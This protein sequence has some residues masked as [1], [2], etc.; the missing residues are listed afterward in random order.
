MVQ[1][2][3]FVW[4]VL[5]L[6]IK[7]ENPCFL[8]KTL[9]KLLYSWTRFFSKNRKIILSQLNYQGDGV[10][11]LIVIFSIFLLREQSPVVPSHPPSVAG[12]WIN[13]TSTEGS[14]SSVGRK[15][16]EHELI[17]YL[18][19]VGFGPSLKTWPKCDPQFLQLTSVRINSGLLMISSKFPP[20]PDASCLYTTLS[21]PMTS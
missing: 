9:S 7:V 20:I 13:S 17:Q 14:E 19:P 1:K 2:H 6:K 18:C 10:S 12:W 4:C 5:Q 11:S 21:L 16:N 8:I 15:S 3:V